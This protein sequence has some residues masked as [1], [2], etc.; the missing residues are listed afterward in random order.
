[1]TEEFDDDD[2]TPSCAERFAPYILNPKSWYLVAWEILLGAIYLSCFIIDPLVFAFNFEPLVDVSLNRGQRILTALL[3]LDMIRIPITGTTKEEKFES[4]RETLTENDDDALKS[5]IER[6][7]NSDFAHNSGLIGSL[8][9]PVLVRDI[10]K[11]LNKY[12][13]GLFI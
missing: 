7:Y 8:D 10:W 13:R 2:T 4:A 1:M 9:D 6:R 3:I 5:R 11:L 12:L